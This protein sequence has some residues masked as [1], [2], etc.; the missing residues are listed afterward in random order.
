MKVREASNEYVL[1][2]ARWIMIT[3]AIVAINV[4]SMGYVYYFATNQFGDEQADL[5]QRLVVSTLDRD[6][7]RLAEE[8]YLHLDTIQSREMSLQNLVGKLG[9]VRLSFVPDGKT[10]KAATK[11]DN[12]TELSTL[13]RPL[14]EKGTF[15]TAIYFDDL[16]VGN[17]KT[18]IKL[19][20]SDAFAK[21][22]TTTLLAVAVLV[23]L[24]RALSILFL[25]RLVFQPFLES[26]R[27]EAD[28]AA[29]GKVAQQVAH[30]IRSPLS[31]LEIAVSRSESM[32]ED[33]RVLVRSAVQRITDIANDLLR[34]DAQSRSHVH[35]RNLTITSTGEQQTH[36]VSSLLEVI[37]SE[38][39]MQTRNRIGL[40]IN[41]CNELI[42][43]DFVKCNAIELQRVLSNL[44][45]NAIE[46]IPAAGT[47]NIIATQADS[48]VKICVNDNGTGMSQETLSRLGDRGFTR[49]KT[50]GK[51][52]GFN[53]AIETVKQ[54]GSKISIES[55]LG[56]GTDISFSLP[57]IKPPKWFVPEVVLQSKNNLVIVDDDTSIHEIWKDR[58]STLRADGFEGKLLHFSSPNSLDSS[59]LGLELENS[60]F[61]FDFEFIGHS[62][63]GIEAI[64]K[65]KI[66]DR[67]FLVTS[68]FEN[69]K[70]RETCEKLGLG[71]IPKTYAFRV[72]IRLERENE[73]ER[74]Q[75]SSGGSL[76]KA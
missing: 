76:D 31:A 8:M 49:G 28:I 57:I 43:G 36:L 7:S 45:N 44:I 61:L 14:A 70:I 64:E 23:V 39:R 56:L 13:T 3:L 72:P 47:I 29:A 63:N 32:P 59:V 38:K 19:N 51:G 12:S 1:F 2:Y 73:D 60:I 35:V 9:T 24:S 37:V 21:L 33:L 20:S 67:S 18:V 26:I 48:K 55:S 27:K 40:E 66:L 42:Y 17:L 15:S 34:R 5:I 6:Y 75:N 22:P 16:L 54:L 68:R 65:M 74:K 41:F 30:D 10:R 58:F 4:C 11:N 69:S 53:H 71:L 50:D 52:L 46:A 62:M 25:R